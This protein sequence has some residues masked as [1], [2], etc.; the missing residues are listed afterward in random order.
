MKTFFSEALRILF[1]VLLVAM[2][3]SSQETEPTKSEQRAADLEAKLR[4]TLESSDE[5]ARVLLELIDLYYEEGQIFG[6]VR[7]GKIFA[8]AQAGHP[9]HEEV[10]GKLI[11]KTVGLRVKHTEETIGLDL[12]QH[13]ERAYGG[14]LR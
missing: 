4:Q 11:D 3:L 14:L 5:G 12:A 2:P 13:G 7:S 9:R 6:L 1:A 10:M 8:T